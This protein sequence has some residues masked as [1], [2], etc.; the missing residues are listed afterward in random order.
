MRKCSKCGELKDLD[1]FYKATGG[2]D[3]LRGDCK[4]CFAARR[5]A[6]Y[7]ENTERE[8]ARVKAWQEANREEYLAKQKKYREEHADEIKAKLRASHLKRKYGITVER[9]NRLFFRQNGRCLLCRALPTDGIS[10]HVDHDHA[11]GRVRGLLCFR[12]N[13]AIGDLR[14]DPELLERAAAY[15]RGDWP[16]DTRIRRQIGR[17]VAALRPS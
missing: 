16:V 1:Q 7:R 9:Y 2:R 17:R 15:L 3:G 11:T 10:L 8:K 5:A 6:W 12:C 13:N 14:D 4:A